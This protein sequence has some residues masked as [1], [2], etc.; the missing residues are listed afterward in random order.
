MRTANAMLL[1]SGDFLECEPAC[2]YHEGEF[3]EIDLLDVIT[4]YGDDKKDEKNEVA[5]DSKL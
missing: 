3:C 5:E 4:L 2:V 1:H